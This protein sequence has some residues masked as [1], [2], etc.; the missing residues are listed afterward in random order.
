[1]L[2][3]MTNFI[4]MA[5]NISAYTCLSHFLHL[6]IHRHSRCF[7]SLI[8]VNNVSMTMV[9]QSYLENC[10]FVSS[11]VYPE[12]GLLIIFKILGLL[13]CFLNNY[14]DLYIHCVPDFSFLPHLC[15]HLFKLAFLL[16]P[17]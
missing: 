2:S 14:T 12:E 13:H 10:D 9:V 5:E 8:I 16:Y 6:S 17:S 1:M 7:N 15:Q 3:P 11:D 4:C